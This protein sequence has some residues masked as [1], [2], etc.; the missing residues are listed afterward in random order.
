MQLLSIVFAA[1]LFKLEV[2]LPSIAGADVSRATGT[3]VG[4]LASRADV[5]G[6]DHWPDGG[7]DSW[8][9]YVMPSPTI[10]FGGE[11][12]VHLDRPE[13]PPVLPLILILRLL[14]P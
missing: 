3:R 11:Y 5:D 1:A 12:V 13:T 2:S 6:V 7:R 10:S 9:V 8:G 4:E 14:V